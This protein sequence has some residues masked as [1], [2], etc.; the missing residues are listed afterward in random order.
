[1]RKMNTL[2][3]RCAGCNQLL[4]KIPGKEPV[5]TAKTPGR[6]CA[7]KFKLSQ[8]ACHPVPLEPLE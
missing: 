7:E 8:Q 5:G 6:C 1:M 2:E 4:R 3:I